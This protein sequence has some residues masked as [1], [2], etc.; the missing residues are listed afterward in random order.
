MNVFPVMHSVPP[1]N[2]LPSCGNKHSANKQS[3]HVNIDLLQGKV[4][5]IANVGVLS[6]FCNCNKSSQNCQT[7]CHL[8][9]RTIWSLS[10][11]KIQKCV[12]VAWPGIFFIVVFV[13]SFFKFSVWSILL[14]LS[15]CRYMWGQAFTMEVN[16]CVTMSTPREYP[17][18]TP[19][20]SQSSRENKNLR[21]K[22][23][24]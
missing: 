4:V 21:K 20:N 14:L 23:K 5:L 8:S 16:R 13:V 15:V 10:S 3:S 12:V 1:S 2:S 7:T 19:G 24:N 9:V 17:A 22:R 6:F 18:L 11:L